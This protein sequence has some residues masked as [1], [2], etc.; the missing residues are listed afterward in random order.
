MK[1]FF[2]MYFTYLKNHVILRADK[3]LMEIK[4]Y[5]NRARY[6]A[7]YRAR[8]NNRYRALSFTKTKACWKG[9]PFLCKSTK[10]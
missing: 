3:I 6:R 8:C 1:R 10:M 2:N 7:R 5:A 4:R 9:W